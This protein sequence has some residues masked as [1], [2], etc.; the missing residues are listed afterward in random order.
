MLG[1]RAYRSAHIEAGIIGQGLYL[2]AQ[3]LDLGASGIGAYYDDDVIG[4]LELDEE[5]TAVIYDFVIGRPTD[6]EHL[7]PGDHL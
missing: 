2:A 3:A 7:V 5:G 6:D 4:F 1:P